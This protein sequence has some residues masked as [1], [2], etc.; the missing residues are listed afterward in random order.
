M[1]RQSETR[2]AIN[3]LLDVDERTPEQDAELHELTETVGST[4]SSTYS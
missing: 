2:E 1:L 4:T 3:R